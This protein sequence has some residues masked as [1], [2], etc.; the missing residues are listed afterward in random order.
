MNSQPFCTPS[1]SPGLTPLRLQAVNARH[2]CASRRRMAFPCSFEF[3]GGDP[4]LWRHPSRNITRSSCVRLPLGCNIPPVTTNR[5]CR[6]RT[7]GWRMHLQS[8]QRSKG[9]CRSVGRVHAR[10]LSKYCERERSA[11]L[12][13]NKRAGVRSYSGNLSDHSP[14][15]SMPMFHL[16]LLPRR[17]LK[18]IGTR[19]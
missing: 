7:A 12:I 8:S 11:P 13:T 2:S 10:S 9:I 3:Q 15:L 6:P 17:L 5:I 18:T 14:R 1:T 16:N 4:R 19:R